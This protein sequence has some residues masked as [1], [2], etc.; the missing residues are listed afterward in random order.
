VSNF[1]DLG[2]YSTREGK[3]VKWGLLYRSGNLSKLSRSGLKRFERLGIHTLIDFRS[4]MEQAQEPDRLPQ[5][6]QIRLLSLPVLDKGSAVVVDEIYRMF[7]ENNF[8]GFD[9]DAEMVEAYEQLAVESAEQYRQFVQSVLEAGGKP[10]L[11]HCTSGKDRAGF[12][13]AIV[14]RLL[15]VEQPAVIGDYMLSAKYADSRKKLRFFLRLVNRAKAASVLKALLTVQEHWIQSAFQ[16]I[17]AHWGGFD[18]Y[19]QRALGLSERD[20]TRLRQLLLD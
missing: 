13:A 2:G 15:G 5:G 8:N 18:A 7:R 4:E 11:W 3:H 10:V 12:A 14:L 1:R 6:H 19:V 20:I 9:P 16:A 17:D